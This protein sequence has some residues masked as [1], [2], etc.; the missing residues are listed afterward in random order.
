[1]QVLSS[2]TFGGPAEEGAEEVEEEQLEVGVGFCSALFGG[3]RWELFPEEGDEGLNE[4]F[5]GER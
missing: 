4:G 2:E 5:Q 1:V 3:F